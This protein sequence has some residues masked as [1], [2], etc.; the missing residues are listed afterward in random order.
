MAS[1]DGKCEFTTGERI[2]MINYSQGH[3]DAQCA[4]PMAQSFN[5]NTNDTK[6]R[7]ILPD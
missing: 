6:I 4:L 3:T 7:T 2:E 1:A 5:F